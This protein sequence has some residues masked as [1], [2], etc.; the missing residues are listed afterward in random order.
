[1]AIFKFYQIFLSIKE[2]L[3]ED[4]AVKIFPEYS[5]LPDKSSEMPADEQAKLGKIVM[6]RMDELLEKDTIVKI[7]RKHTC[8]LTKKQIQEIN[9]LKEKS[10]SLDEFCVKYSKLLSPGYVKKDGDLLTVSFGWNK[11]VCGMFRKLDK[12]EPVS[13]TWC[14]CC[15]GHVIKMYSLICDKIVEA[16]IQETVA[17]GGQDCI[18]KVMLCPA[19]D[20][21]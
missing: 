11:C 15:N 12:Y 8:N 21:I 18:F 19:K 3:G 13:K 20:C 2:E 17:S 5:T 4:M 6:D 14:E 9:E 16:E 10:G 7:R 1:M